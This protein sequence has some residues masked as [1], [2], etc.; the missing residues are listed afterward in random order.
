M[1]DQFRKLNAQWSLEPVCRPDVF[2]AMRTKQPL[3]ALGC[4]FAAHG[5]H[6]TVSVLLTAWVRN[7]AGN[8][9]GTVLSAEMPVRCGVNPLRV[10]ENIAWYLGVK[11]TLAVNKLTE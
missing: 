7:F 1:W 8:D 4:K 11:K 5:G 6:V 3:E 10:A 2:E 9:F